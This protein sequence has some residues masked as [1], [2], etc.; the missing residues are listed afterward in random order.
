MTTYRERYDLFVFDLD[1][2]LVD[3][4]EDLTDSV[5]HALR[6]VGL[7]PLDV[8][9]VTGYV[10]NGVRI[11][12][13]KALGEDLPDETVE[14]AVAEFLIRYQ[15]GCTRKTRLYPGV[16]ETLRA[17]DPAPL[18][19]LTNKPLEPTRKILASLGLE[20]RFR[21]VEGGDS[22]PAR[23]PD[24]QALLAMAAD[25]RVPPQRTLFVGDSDVD[26]LT[27][28][29]AG[30]GAAFVTYGFRPDA[31]KETPPDYRLTSFTELLG[32]SRA[33]R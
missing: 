27:A 2:T 7:P 30:T 5:N 16:E 8:D 18:M 24:P 1:G 15:E 17:L 6:T 10:G 20:D 3:T 28:R 32:A 26:V 4:R 21:R 23:K 33:A 19:V 12:M 11:L 9:T 14:E 13:R 22:V 25:A 31:W 29:A